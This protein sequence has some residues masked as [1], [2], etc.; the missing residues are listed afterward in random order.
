[1][2]EAAAPK[3]G[4]LRE[5][6]WRRFLRGPDQA[7]L[8]ELYV[9]ALA[10]AVRYDRCCA[11]FS[12]SVLAAA[13]RGFGALIERL[14]A[15][16]AAA[17]RPAVRLIVNEELAEEDVRALIE[18]GDTSAL[19]AHLLRRLKRPKD[20]L[21][22]ERLG[23]LAW[24]AK[25]ELLEARVGVLRFGE[26][27]V[28]AKF[29]VV[30]DSAG[31][32]LVF[33]GSGNESAAGLH[34][35]YEEIEVST[36][37][38]DA[39]RLAYFRGR[40]DDLWNDL[41][42]T[43]HTV[44]LP[45]A[46]R[47]KLIKFAP[48]ELKAG[49][50]SNALA[51]QRAAMLWRFIAEA[52][53]LENGA[54]ACDATAFVR[55][56]PHQRQ[57]VE[58]VANAWPA[59]RLLCDEVGMGK[60]IEAILVLRR[61]LA[62]R[63]VKRVLILL[64][65]GL[66]IQWQ[67]ELREKGGLVFPRF[68]IFKGLVWPDGR[69]Q[70]L[71][72][73]LAE[74]LREDRLI[75]SRETARTENSRPA[76]LAAE[77]WDLV[78]LDEAHA[79]RRANQIETEFNSATLLLELLRQLQLQ[80]KA[81]GILLLSA[82]PMQTHPWEPWDLLAVL[83]E[84]GH[85]LS[86]FSVVRDYYRAA[87]AVQQ[88]HCTLPTAKAA[89]VAL[90]LD[91]TVAPPPERQELNPR[92]VSA[93][94]KALAFARPAEREGLARWMRR[95]SPLARRMHR[96]TRET[97]R[98]Y[99]AMGLIECP[100]AK[101]IVHDELFDFHDPAERRVYDAITR[102]I[103]RRFAELENEKPGK[104][105][106]M[107]VYRRRAAS[108]PYALEQSLVR[109]AQGLR[110]V[111]ARQSADLY[112]DVELDP[113]DR[114]DLGDIDPNGRVSAAL[115]TDPEIAR[116]EL[117]DV[118]G[119]L[120]QLRALGGRDSKRDKFYDLLR[121]VTNDG[122]AV[123][124]FTE[125]ADTMH[126][127]RDQLVGAYGKQLGCYSGE[128]GQRW[129]GERWVGMPKDEIARLL[130]N[131]ELRLLV[132]TDAASEGLNLQAAGALINFDLPWNPSKVEQRIGRIDRIGQRHP[133][134]RIVNLFLKDSV[135]EQVYRTLRQRCGLFEHF[136][137]RMQPVLAAARKVFLDPTQDPLNA[138]R[139]AAEEVEQE[140]LAAETYIESEAHQSV[141]VAAPLEL[142]DL[143][144]ALSALDGSFGLQAKEVGDERFRI[145]GIAGEFALSE[146]A[147]D[148]DET[149]LP[150]TPL[151][152]IV[153]EIAASLLRPGEILPLVAATV[154]GGAF[155]ATECVWV[156][157]RRIERVTC[158][159]QLRTLVHAWDGTYPDPRRRQDA[160]EAAR[161]AAEARV[162]AA[163]RRAEELE[164]EALSR[165]LD[166]ARQR[167]L[168]ELGKYLVCIGQGTGDLNAVLYGQLQREDIV[169]R[170][171][172]KRV[173]ERFGGDYPQWPEHLLEE[174][175]SFDR[176]VTANE[177]RGRLIG[178]E[179]DAALADPRWVARDAMR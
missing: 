97:L 86:E 154:A 148:R 32:A 155:R 127:L 46:V 137:G 77:P 129:D 112:A 17:P 67:Q 47:L 59:G 174:L 170:E 176:R 88:G 78:L 12:S 166:A 96:N 1:M 19:E 6:A 90:A 177:R 11:Y 38:T 130:Q 143:R 2:N 114:D 41:D 65:A 18:R 60:T 82:T 31:D 140:P 37:W 24:L 45:E 172:L 94:A 62:G 163:M 118:E 142:G 141:S 10:A 122:R 56:W 5:R 128:G 79:A 74:A 27:I 126:Y 139:R 144:H 57:V 100:P 131:G 44:P 151:S 146:E 160:E 152:S 30:T 164:R 107:T 15:L 124:V 162:Q 58:D 42:A 99:H 28:H 173:L 89:A 98:R 149:A 105:F 158:Y 101:R 93:V 8:D 63:G 48:R 135:D 92:E 80:R 49:E 22:K 68:D 165:Q 161:R 171:R 136:V 150:L 81:R 64:P 159:A 34:A 25:R 167:L 26:G 54:A 147:L 39:E 71:D 9:P 20:A 4:L 76:V 169:S 168:R 109:R 175:A 179:L 108:S 87:V 83:G 21:E 3:T 106:V 73:G 16:G 120:E 35:N 125:Y 178:K 70:R 23:M 156:G 102:Y 13:A 95:A 157:D 138:I 115:P 72:G 116:R 33:N 123:L 111:C 7:L 29:G 110:R 85:W 91:P 117:N 119:L 134:I 113:R 66:Q 43:V 84:G 61:L 52:P 55:M 121:I 103:E 51:R 145:G 133:E 104:G 75:L 153:S 69:E 132:C 36:S 50:P 40:F 53:Y 14:I